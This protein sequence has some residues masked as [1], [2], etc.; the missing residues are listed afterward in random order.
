MQ[1]ATYFRRLS[2]DQLA[3]AIKDIQR[4]ID[5][6]RTW[7]DNCKGENKYLDQLAEAV[8]ERNRR[9]NKHICPNCNRPL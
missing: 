4:A 5:V 7:D 6:A 2:N 1:D 8:N 9:E 3:M